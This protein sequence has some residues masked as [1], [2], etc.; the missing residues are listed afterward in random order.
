LV[1]D[2]AT[3]HS[4]ELRDFNAIIERSDCLSSLVPIGNGELL[5]LKP[6]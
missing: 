4:D 3:S 2:N 1:V 5:V 6:L